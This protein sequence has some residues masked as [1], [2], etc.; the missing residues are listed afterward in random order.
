MTNAKDRFSSE[1]CFQA[2]DS[3]NT[4]FKKYPGYGIRRGKRGYTRV[5]SSVVSGSP[6]TILD[7]MQAGLSQIGGPVHRDALVIKVCMS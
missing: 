7:G 2:L 1:D 6:Q 5:R 4:R 3:M